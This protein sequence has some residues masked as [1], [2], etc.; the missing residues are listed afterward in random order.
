M[1]GCQAS[2]NIN[3]RS[4]AR[5]STSS[6]YLIYKIVKE[7]ANTDVSTHP[8]VIMNLSDIISKVAAPGS[9]DDH[10][11]DDV[12]AGASF[13]RKHLRNEAEGIHPCPDPHPVGR[14]SEGPF[15]HRNSTMSRW[16]WCLP[17]LLTL[18]A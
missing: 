10:V 16:S 6:D 5:T 13:K 14:A 8:L 1:C 12:L 4:F 7:E 11:D 9:R 17:R 18:M 2:N 3:K 15:P